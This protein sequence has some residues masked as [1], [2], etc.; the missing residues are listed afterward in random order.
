M[1][2]FK[3][4]IKDAQHNHNETISN[5]KM[6]SGSEHSWLLHPLPK[7][8]LGIFTIFT[9]EYSRV[10]LHRDHNSNPLGFTG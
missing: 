10:V 1:N 6:Y 5:T 3:Q 8:S 4:N 7:I 2:V 9:P